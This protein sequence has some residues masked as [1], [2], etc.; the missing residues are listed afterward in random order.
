MKKNN[1]GS[2]INLSSLPAYSSSK[3]AID[4]L[5]NLLA[6]AYAP[7]HNRVNVVALGWIETPLLTA[8]KENKEINE[9]LL[10]R[11]PMNRYGDPSVVV[12]VIAFLASTAASF[13]TGVTLSIDGGYLTSGI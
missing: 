12:Q 11:T 8:L 4:S 3:G 10:S 6:E 2:I 13:V 7:D 5:T 1:G 9:R